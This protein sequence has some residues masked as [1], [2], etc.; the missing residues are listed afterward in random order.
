[1]RR[2]FLL[3]FF[4]VPAA[5]AELPVLKAGHPS[6]AP[7]VL[8]ARPPAPADNT[9]SEARAGLGKMLFFDPRL[10][11]SGQV[12]CASCHMPERGWADGLPTAIR[13]HGTPVPLATPPLAN[14]GYATI[15]MWD[16]R[17]PTLEQQAVG[18]QGAQSD[19]NNGI[20]RLKPADTVR[21]IG[22]IDGYRAAFERAYPGEGVT[23]ASIGRA[24]A[25]FQRSLVSR[26]SPFDRWLAGDARA[27]T[28]AQVNGF[29]VFL[30]P[31]RGACAVCHNAPNFTDGSF[32]NVGL[33]SYGAATPLPGRGRHQPVKMMDGAFKTPGLRDVALTAP[34]FHDGSARTLADVVAHY[35][36][37]GEVR[38]NLSPLFRKAELTAQ[39]QADLVSFLEALTTPA[40]P[41][42][43]PVL[44]ASPPGE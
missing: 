9:W 41:F 26:D 15:F 6:L 11:T 2:F 17:Q 40:K 30:D 43:Y 7:W 27:M 29:R 44:P 21:L 32:H 42:V 16:G 25:A 33:K 20:G 12:T 8:P 5:A 19:L 36:R 31:A 39:E 10:S 3:A 37:G 23:T 35:A 14:I 22:S 34:Y 24:L 1:M 28:S 18:G 13:F 4:L 38:T